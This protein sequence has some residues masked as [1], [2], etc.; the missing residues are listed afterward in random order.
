MT[1]TGTQTKTFN[2]TRARYV[3]SKL[4]A[5]LKLL[6]RAY[7]APSNADIEA[8]SEEA[9]LLLQYGL[10]GDVTFGFRRRDGNWVLALRYIARIDGTLEA[11]DRAGRV[12]RGVDVTGAGFHSYL[13]YSAVWDRLDWQ[14]RQGIKKSLPVIRTAAPPP[15]TAGGYW[16]SDKVYSSNGSGLGRMSFR[17]T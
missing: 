2:I 4:M 11:D 16:T 12:P 9:A 3:T 1:Q 8:Y 10:L 15:G 6:Q 14:S 5:D 17:A 7:D 13:T